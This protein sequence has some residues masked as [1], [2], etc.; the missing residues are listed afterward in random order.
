VGC[1]LVVV[2]GASFEARA[3]KSD[4]PTEEQM[5]ALMEVIA[6]PR[7][8][9][10]SIAGEL[11][12]Y[13]AFGPGGVDGVGAA[14]AFDAT[15]RFDAP[16]MVRG[17]I[18]PMAV[19]WTERESAGGLMASAQV[20]LDLHAFELRV[21][22]GVTSINAFRDTTQLEGW[23]FALLFGVRFGV[24][25]GL[26]VDFGG[27]I[28]TT[29]GGVIP[30]RIAMHVQV[31]LGLEWALFMRVDAA[32]DG[33]IRSGAGARFWVSGRGEPGSI[34]L[35]LGIGVGIAMFAPPSRPR[36]FPPSAFVVGLGPDFALEGRL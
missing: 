19:G 15:Y 31:P 8:V 30:A 28:V 25:D 12:V 32:V 9:G 11:I 10:G 36:G 22:A 7:R 33:V 24:V 3:Q 21:G 16:L 4:G 13:P 17:E 34:S 23:G 2:L 1:V 35:R 14:G 18:G 29:S 5:R 27:G 6:P 20:G 26:F